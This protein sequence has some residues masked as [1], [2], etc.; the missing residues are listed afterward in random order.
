MIGTAFEVRCCEGSNCLAL[1]GKEFEWGEVERFRSERNRDFSD[2]EGLQD[3]V[4][5]RSQGRL[6]ADMLFEFYV[7]SGV[8]SCEAE[9]SDVGESV[10]GIPGPFS[11]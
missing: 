2:G 7:E 8:T 4:V 11:M 10:V 6:P 1:C 9:G 5:V 3:G